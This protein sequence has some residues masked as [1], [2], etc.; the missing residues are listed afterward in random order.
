[1]LDK[2]GP[3]PVSSRLFWKKINEARTSK[4][5]AAI[6]TL[7]K[8]SVEYKTDEEKAKVFALMLSEIYAANDN[9]NDYDN[10]FKIKIDKEVAELNLSNDF[11]RFSTYD[12]IKSIQKIKINSAP[13]DDQLHNILLKNIPYDYV[14]TVLSVLVNR[15]A[16]TGIPEEW[17]KAKIIM[18]PKGEKSNDP[19]KY[20]PI[21]LTSCLGKLIE[22][23][24]KKRLVEFLEI[25]I[26]LLNN[27][28]ASDTRKEQPII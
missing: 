15:A 11:V 27:N 24:F 20:R 17:K 22:R 5:S 19:E 28:L 1:M 2:F 4:K 25:K 10:V 12:I 14:N 9:A 16:N 21:S 8:D 6:P 3:Y 23:L 18:I 13:G 26:Y 7:V